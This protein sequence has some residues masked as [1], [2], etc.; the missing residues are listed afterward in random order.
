M[1]QAQSLST[2][3]KG[4]YWENG[5]EACLLIHGFAGTP[6][7]LKLLADFL[8][9]QGYTISAPCLAGHGASLE[10]LESCEWRQ[11]VSSVEVA[12]KQLLH[13]YRTVHV[14]GLSMGSLLAL[15]LVKTERPVSLV[16]M[17]PPLVLQNKASMF[18]GIAKHFV[19]AVNFSP[20]SLPDGNEQYMLGN[21][22]TPLRGVE[23][24]RYMTKRV[25]ASLDKVQTPILI[26]DAAKDE[27]VDNRSASIITSRV[28]SQKKECV[29]LPDSGHIIPLDVNRDIAFSAIL[30]FLRGNVK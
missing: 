1:E 6:V 25:I 21:N 23:Q 15:D 18:A 9:E 3:R 2:L 20:L 27:M 7:E 12:Y 11:W 29:T 24:M 14:L 4:Y 10:E 5:E 26:I 16:V 17:A 13:N 22:K 30:D 28:S 19:R 8:Y